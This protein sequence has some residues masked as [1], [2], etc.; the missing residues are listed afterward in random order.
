MRRNSIRHA[1]PCAVSPTAMNDPSSG[2]QASAPP[3]TARVLVVDDNRINRTKMRMAVEHLGYSAETANNGAKALELLRAQAFDAV[4]LD[5]VMPEVDGFDVLAIIK[6]DP[7]LRDI[8]VVVI[9]A[10]DD[11][12]E[13]V[14]RAISLGAEDFLPKSFDPVLL[15]A[16]LGA[17]VRRC[18]RPINRG[19]ACEGGTWRTRT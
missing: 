17:S 8:P 19:A 15:K 11:E 2:P 16:R 14:V 4:L 6:D 13:S 1:L 5:I 9:S 7:S 10:L 3:A 12:T 18:S